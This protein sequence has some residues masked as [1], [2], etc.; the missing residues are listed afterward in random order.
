[1]RVGSRFF[2]RFNYINRPEKVNLDTV[3]LPQCYI[4]KSKKL[5]KFNKLGKSMI[6]YMDDGSKES[7]HCVNRLWSH[8]TLKLMIIIKVIRLITHYANVM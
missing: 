2:Y 7:G 3:L 1:M 4:F 5:M 8:L 6:D